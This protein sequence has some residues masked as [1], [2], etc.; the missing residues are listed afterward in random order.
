MKFR[1]LT[2]HWM[3]KLNVKEDT[4]PDLLDKN[5]CEFILKNCSEELEDV[6]LSIRTYTQY[7][8]S[9]GSTLKD[10]LKKRQD[11][12]GVIAKSKR[13]AAALKGCE[14]EEEED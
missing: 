12:Q 1:F 6:E 11:L 4:C 14:D 8:A 10:L 9:Y 7:V 3:V 2:T 5:Q 13:Q